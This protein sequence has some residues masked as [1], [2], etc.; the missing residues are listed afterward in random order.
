MFSREGISPE[1]REQLEALLED[2]YSAFIAAVAGDRGKSEAEVRAWVDAG[3]YRGQSAEEAGLI[4]ACLFPDQVEKELLRLAPEAKDQEKEEPRMV[5][6]DTYYHLRG[7]GRDRGP[8]WRDGSRLA[9]LVVSGMIRRGSRGVVPLAG[10]FEVG[11]G[12]CV[13]RMQSLAQ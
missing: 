13:K 10:T 6:N 3:P 5:S 2:R 8:V 1:Q 7:C 11:V 4:D 9:Y 12:P